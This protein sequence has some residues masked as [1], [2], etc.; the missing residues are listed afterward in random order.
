[1]PTKRLPQAGTRRRI[2]LILVTANRSV[3]V[4]SDWNDPLATLIKRS[5]TLA[6]HR[7]SVALEPEFWDSLLRLAQS[8]G[9]VVSG[10]VAVVD[11]ERTPDRPLASALRV[12][13]LLAAEA[14]TPVPGVAAD[15]VG[16]QAGHDSVSERND[17]SG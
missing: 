10:L 13:A 15:V 8:R 9:Q 16:G 1:L 4:G 5:F 11:A 3:E 7:T 2:D 6:G 14:R 17:D 12:T